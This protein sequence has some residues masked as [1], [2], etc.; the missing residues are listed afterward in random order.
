M[1]IQSIEKLLQAVKIR[2]DSLHEAE[3]RMAERLAPNFNLFDFFRGDEN[4]ISLCLACLLDPKGTHGQ[5][6][7]FLSLFIKQLPPLARGVPNWLSN[8]PQKIL[9]ER[10]TDKIEQNNRRIDISIEWRNGVV[11]IENKPWANDQDQQLADYARHLQESAKGL[12]FKDNWLLIYLSDRE[13][14]KSSLP[15]EQRASYRENGNY[16]EIDYTM[17]CAWLDEC[18]KESKALVIRVFIEEL[19]KYIRSSVMGELENDVE[20]EVVDLILA[21]QNIE[22]A[23][24]VAKSFRAAQM[25]LLERFFAKLRRDLSHSQYTLFQ[26]YESRVFWQSP[27]DQIIWFA[28]NGNI[29]GQKKY[30]CF[31]FVRPGNSLGWGI[32][33]KDEF[34]N[35]TVDEASW[36]EIN[37]S[38]GSCLNR[39]GRLSPPWWPWRVDALSDEFD[40]IDVRDWNDSPEPWQAMADGRLAN[41]IVKLAC[42]I[43]GDVFK[44][45]ELLLC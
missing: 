34:A 4:G 40:G 36:K 3:R 32:K 39:S 22:G 18:A 26:P 21:D 11:G 30:L 19:A 37:S 35:E 45:K 5:G 17:L 1:Q 24:L 43:Y 12:G 25:K 23:F 16:V 29:A 28:I 38:M 7:K 15:P 6:H 10:A 13:P 2:V 33:R 8:L 9:T 20:N 14:D 44:G 31:E 27:S 42:K 41:A